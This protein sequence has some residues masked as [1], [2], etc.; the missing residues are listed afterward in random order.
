MAELVLFMR[1]EAPIAAPAE[2]SPARRPVSRGWSLAR[3]LPRVPAL[4]LRG[5][6]GAPLMFETD[7]GVTIFLEIQPAGDGNAELRGQ[8]VADDQDGWAGA[9]IELRQAGTLGATAVIDD[10]GTFRVGALPTQPTELR[11]TRADG[12]ALL[13]PEFELAS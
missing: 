5:A 1:D 9:L 12:R 6:A 13:L 11:I 10:M 7:N 4:A 8:L 2:P 3:L